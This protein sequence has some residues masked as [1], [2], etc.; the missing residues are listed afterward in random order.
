MIELED[1]LSP[2]HVRL[3][4]KSSTKPEAV[5]EI[6]QLLEQDGRIRDWGKFEGAVLGK[7]PATMGHGNLGVCIAHAR[8]DAV[9]R[10]ITSAGRSNEGVVFPDLKQPVRLIFVVGIP[11]AMDSEYLRLIGAIAR[12]CQ[13]GPMVSRLLSVSDP[14]D[15]IAILGQG[16]RR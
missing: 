4:T 7:D 13:D 10:I 5:Q 12:T 16:E 11:A 9:G 3:D 1:I 8:T 15:F 6:L 14:K 2:D